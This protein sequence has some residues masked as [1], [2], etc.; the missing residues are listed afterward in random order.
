M[1]KDQQRVECRASSSISPC[2]G[3]SRPLPTRQR[4]YHAFAVA[5][6]S[7]THVCSVAGLRCDAIERPRHASQQGW[8]QPAPSRWECHCPFRH[9]AYDCTYGISAGSAKQAGYSSHFL[10]CLHPDR[11]FYS[12]RDG[13][14]DLL[15][16]G[17]CHQYHDIDDRRCKHRHV[18]GERHIDLLLQLPQ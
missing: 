16:Y 5:V 14:R 13:H 11:L 4:R 2:A 8:C 6:H 3:H 9:L 18:L 1:S 15:H 7:S 17:K 12:V 10:L